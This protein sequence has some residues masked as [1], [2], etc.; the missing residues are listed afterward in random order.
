MSKNVRYEKAMRDR[1]KSEG[2]FLVTIDVNGKL[3]R[4]DSVTVQMGVDVDTA[5]TLFGVAMKLFT[6][7]KLEPGR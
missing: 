4:D 5:K 2:K 3:R 6:N 7:K 1:A